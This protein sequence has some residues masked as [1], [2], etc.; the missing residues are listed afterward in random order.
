MSRVFDLKAG[1][2]IRLLNQNCY[3]KIVK[4]ELKPEKTGVART[5]KLTF[6]DGEIGCYCSDGVV[7]SAT[8]KK[9]YHD[10]GEILEIDND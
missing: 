5:I 8:A 6:E 10:I 7:S 4:T 1:D 2:K 3:R 9:Y